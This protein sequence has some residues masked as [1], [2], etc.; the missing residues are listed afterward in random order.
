MV[1]ARSYRDVGRSGRSSSGMYRAPFIIHTVFEVELQIAF[2][3][4]NRDRAEPRHGV[5]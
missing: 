3:T 2:G 5:T 4:S 1:V